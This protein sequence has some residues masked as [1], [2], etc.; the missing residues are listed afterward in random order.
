MVVHARANTLVFVRQYEDETLLIALQR[1]GE[2]HCVLSNSPIIPTGSW[3]KFDGEGK[4]AQEADYIELT[5]PT[6]SATVW[7]WSAA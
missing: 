1:D 5:L 7:Q 4:L 2:G 3:E 6:E